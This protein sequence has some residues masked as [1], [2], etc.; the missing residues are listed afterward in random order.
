MTTRRILITGLNGTVAPK[1]AKEAENRGYDV[2]AWPRKLV[3]PENR[4]E[5]ELFLSR[6]NLDAIV[7]MA[8]GAESWAETISHFAG[9]KKIPMV[10]ASSVMVFGDRRNGPFVT[11]DEPDGESDYG[12]YK[13]RCEQAVRNANSRSCIIRMGWQICEDGVGNNMVAYLDKE[14]KEHGRIMCSDSWIPACGY[15]EDSAR[16]IMKCIDERWYGLFHMD[17]NCED[18]YSFARIV[19]YLNA[20]MNRRWNI[21]THND[22]RHDQRLR[23]SYL[24][25]FRNS[26][27]WD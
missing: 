13:V 7:H 14:Q 23:D 10:F 15:M 19:K 26:V 24:P 20:K 9:Y 25:V 8:C 3:N 11:S 18:G 17:G 4:S 6:M 27:H 21:V 16:T 2:I 5:A 22:Y 1:V 12:R